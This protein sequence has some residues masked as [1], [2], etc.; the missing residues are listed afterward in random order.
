MKLTVAVKLQPAPE[1][2]Y[3]L[4]S[5][6]ETANRAANQVSQTAWNAQTF[7]QY[8]I[9]KLTYHSVKDAFGLT[10]QVVVRLIAKVADAYKLDRRTRRL[11]RPHGSIAFDDRI[12]R[13]RL[14]HST[15]SIWTTAGRV[16]IPFVCGERQRAMLAARQGESDLVYRE[17]EW[18]LFATVN[19]DEPPPGIVEEFLGVDLGIVNLATD[20]DGNTYSGAT[21]E[22]IRKRYARARASLQQRGTKGAKKC[23]RRKAG[24]EA[25]FRAHTNHVI[26]KELVTRAK[27]TK[28]GIALEDLT[29]IRSRTTVR[30]SQRA[31]HSG[32]AFFQLRSFVAYKAR[33]SGVPVVLVDPRNTSRTCSACGHCEK[34]NRRSQAEFICCAC[35]LTLNADWN[36]SLNISRAAV[37][38][39]PELVALRG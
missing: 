30:H 31:R 21:V 23:L 38:R 8:A 33:L 4:L 16:T 17:G 2:A 11:F 39:L 34:A 12:L 6:L 22:H 3:A 18:Y 32:W 14:D 25:R 10:A 24:R 9:H 5:T 27:D 26:S 15:V 19:V 36:A 37:N 28:R 7:G 20:S 13:W 1:Q 35:G 29:G